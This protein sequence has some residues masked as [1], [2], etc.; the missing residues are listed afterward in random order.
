MAVAS[1]GSPRRVPVPWAS[2]RWMSWGGRWALVR[3]WVMTW[4]WAVPLGAVRPLEAPSWLMAL[5]RMMAWMG[6]LLWWASVRGSRMRMALP[7]PQPVPS[8]WW[9]K[10]WQRPSGAMPGWRENS[11]NR[12]GVDMTVV[13]PAR[14][15]VVSP[16][17]REVQAR[18]RATRLE[19]QAVSMVR[20]GPDRPSTYDNRPDMTLGVVPV[21]R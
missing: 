4:G 3:A 7:W 14:A 19:E 2:M 9:E 6:W 13:P 18:W 21:S 12:P 11:M 20:E 8:A 10:G 17:R 5:P 16:V 1:M 15:R